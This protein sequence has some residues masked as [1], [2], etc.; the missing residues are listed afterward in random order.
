M[1]N[2]VE[3]VLN[4]GQRRKYF[5]FP[6]LLGVLISTL[7]RYQY[8]KTPLRHIDTLKTLKVSLSVNGSPFQYI[9]DIS[10]KTD[11]INELTKSL[12]PNIWY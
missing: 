7:Y 8:R 10:D 12:V 6:M 11:I 3:I 1:E 2:A 9:S 5:L 4:M